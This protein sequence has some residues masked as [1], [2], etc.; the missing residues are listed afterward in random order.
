MLSL[1]TKFP[2]TVSCVVRNITKQDLQ[3]NKKG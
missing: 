3:Y 2:T 1:K